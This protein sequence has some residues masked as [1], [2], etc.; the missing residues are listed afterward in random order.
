MQ[1][2]LG[3]NRDIKPETCLKLAFEQKQ[4]VM[5]HYMKFEVKKTFMLLQLEVIYKFYQLAQKTSH[6]FF[7]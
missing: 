5:Q 6:K 3:K 7:F 2:K 1:Q 4:K